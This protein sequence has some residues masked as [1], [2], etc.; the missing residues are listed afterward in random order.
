MSD[1]TTGVGDLARLI[2]AAREAAHWR[3][4][5]TQPDPRGPY[6]DLRLNMEIAIEKLRVLEDHAHA[7]DTEGKCDICSF[8]APE[9]ILRGEW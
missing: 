6:R 5:E 1:P 3:E 4:K 9:G 8:G 2:L 7:L